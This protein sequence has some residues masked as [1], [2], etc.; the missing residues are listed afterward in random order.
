M[1][2]RKCISTQQPGPKADYCAD[3]IPSFR[4]WSGRKNKTISCKNLVQN[5][6]R[7]LVRRWCSGRP[8]FARVIQQLGFRTQKILANVNYCYVRRRAERTSLGPWLENPSL[9]SDCSLAAKSRHMLNRI[10]QNWAKTVTNI[11]RKLN[12]FTFDTKDDLS[13]ETSKINVR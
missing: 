13:D 3:P 11:I 9:P 12:M 5:R 1:L 2:F 10:K 6:N 4:F 8:Y 7:L